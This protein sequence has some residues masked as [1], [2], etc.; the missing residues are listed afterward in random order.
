MLVVAVST[1]SALAAEP[2][3]VTEAARAP[4]HQKTR[5][6]VVNQKKKGFCEHLFN[7]LGAFPH[8]LG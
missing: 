5:C 1:A 6:P 3:A 4:M 2:A 8:G 7:A